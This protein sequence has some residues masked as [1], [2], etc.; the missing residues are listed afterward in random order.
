[1]NLTVFVSRT[2]ANLGMRLP[3][4]QTEQNRSRLISRFH[5]RT[6]TSA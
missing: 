4:L 2:Y 3:I 5:F 1:M 6:G